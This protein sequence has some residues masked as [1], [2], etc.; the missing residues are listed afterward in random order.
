MAMTR[1]GFPAAVA[2]LSALALAAGLIT[3]AD[4]E[5]RADAA[6]PRDGVPPP[7]VERLEPSLEIVSASVVPPPIPV[8]SGGSV[9][10]EGYLWSGHRVAPE[11]PPLSDGTQALDGYMWGAGSGLPERWSSN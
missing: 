5:G 11:T 4:L 6:G 7:A 3:L 10:M 1:S 9:A 8:R 2:T